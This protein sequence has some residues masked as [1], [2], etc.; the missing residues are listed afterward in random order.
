MTADFVWI[1][2]YT[3]STSA[4]IL[5]NIGNK[6]VVFLCRILVYMNFLKCYNKVKGKIYILVKTGE[7]TNEKA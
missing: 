5:K 4:H 2:K 1:L 6:F 7:I 3:L